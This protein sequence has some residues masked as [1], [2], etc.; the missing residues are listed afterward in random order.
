MK[1]GGIPN[2]HALSKE[3][4]AR[5]KAL[6]EVHEVLP[7]SD[8][9]ELKTE[10]DSLKEMGKKFAAL[11]LSPSE[12]KEFMR[13]QKEDS[14]GRAGIDESAIRT[15]LGAEYDTLKS[16]HED[17]DDLSDF[18]LRR[19]REG[20]SNPHAKR[21]HE[22]LLA[23]IKKEKIAIEKSLS[24]KEK[25]D[26]NIARAFELIS[27]KK[28]LF[29]EGHIAHTPSVDRH[30]G[31]IGRRMI[32]GKPMFLHGPTGTGKTSLARYAAKHF[33]GKN[34]EMVYCTP[35][36]RD[37]HIWGK[38]GIRA[39]G[40]KG[41]I[42]TVDIYGPLVR[43]MH[44]GSVVVF[45][46]FT[47]LPREQMVFF[48]GIANA[49]PG[50]RITVPG[51]GEI[52][53]KPGFQ[54]IFTANLKSEKNPERQELPPEITREFEQNNLEV[55]YAPKEEAYDIMLAR[56]MKPGGML[57]MSWYDLQTTLP[58][59]CEAMEEIQI[60]YADSARSETAQL[61]GALSISGKKPGLKKFVMT[62]GTIEAILESWGPEQQLNEEISFSEFLDDRLATG[63]TFKEYPESDRV[64]AAKILAS[65]GFLRTKTAED[66]G[67][68]SDVFDFDAGR[69]NGK[70]EA[71]AALRAASSKE[72]PLPLKEVAEL[73]PFAL[74]GKSMKS[75]AEE[76]VGADSGE[77][78]SEIAFE[79]VE[80][81]F[82]KDFFGPADIEKVFGVRL[83][84]VPEIPFSKE[85][86]DTAKKLNQQ[87][88]Y[89]HD[90]MDMQNPDTGKM[91]R[92]TPI[93]LE[94]LKKFF[95]KAHDGKKVFYDRDW[96]K[97]EDFF[98]K[99][100][101]RTG[102]RLTSKDLLPGSTPKS[103][104]EQT[105]MLVKHLEKQ[106]FKN[107]KLPKQ[108]EDAVA[109]F[110]RKR[111]EIEPLAKSATDSEWK[112]GS[113]MLVDLAITKLTRELPVE[114]MYR[115]IL[116]DLARKEKLLPSE[117][118]WTAGRGSGG[119]LVYV[120]GFGA[121]GAR[122]GGYGPGH[123]YGLLGV[124]FSRR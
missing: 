45:D 104:L 35:Q 32:N 105:D 80:R 54:M 112:R 53:I 57:T 46:E 116:N 93:T 99:E 1:E 110:N 56:L 76:L 121:G 12:T 94:N 92:G 39:E 64:L 68:P 70:E 34:A 120:G 97:D 15:E 65:K 47:A 101:P 22:S 38:T 49:K 58:K 30:L 109:E 52:A 75:A 118:T 117:Y 62:Q 17:F 20:A 108:Y 63:L 91:E 87:L 33:T 100:K 5:R 13:K 2:F 69:K 102:W 111:S 96:Y 55:R 95:T 78:G 123:C 41:A 83:D 21:A 23:Q 14:A 37:T 6:K 36:T 66:L 51:N 44:D 26:P 42:K 25:S 86:L 90:V 11:K 18:E 89:Q 4:S 28:G 72:I 67:L 71:I 85:E 77:I 60:A 103:Y 113:Q 115:L 88:I 114:A 73:D 59:L 48:K 43:A 81:L 106:I 74:R 79:D 98:K 107:T 10:I 124:S 119:G 50:D 31:E 84:A 24:E 40:D 8:T 29:E 122:V 9:S 3:L 7:K 82:G 61:V 16:L 27:F 19:L